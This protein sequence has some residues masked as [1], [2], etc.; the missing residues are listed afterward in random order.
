MTIEKK[1]IEL[2]VKVLAKTELG[3]ADARVRDAVI[4]ELSD[5]H[6]TMARE[7]D[8]ILREFCDKDEEGAPLLTKE[9]SGQETYH[10]SPDVIESLNGE[11]AKLGDETV[12]V[13]VDGPERA[14][15]VK[16]FVEETEYKPLFGEVEDI[17]AIISKIV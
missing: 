3:L 8:A 2:F 12:A 1:Y 16:S 15:K 9:D 10:F 5:S 14:E 17:D 13:S 6:A 7:R 4:R 11:L